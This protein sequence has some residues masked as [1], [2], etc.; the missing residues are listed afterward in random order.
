MRILLYA[1][2]GGVGKTS[3]AAA[4][5]VLASRLG[6]NTLVMS[7]DPAHSLCDAFDLDRSLMDKNRGA[8]IT[9]KDRLSIQELDVHEEISRY[10]GEVHKYISVLLSASGIEDVLAEEL[11]VLPGMEEVAALLYVNQYAKENTYDLIVLDCAPTAESIRFVSLPKTLE[12]YMQKVF[13]VERKLVRYMRPV[14]KRVSDIPLPEDEYFASIESLFQRLQGVDLLLTDSEITS[15]RLV[16]NL[17]KMVLRETQ[18][19]F[20]F[21]S[22]HQL[23]IDAVIIN[24]VFPDG[25]PCNFMESWQKSQKEYMDLAKSYFHPVPLLQIPFYSSEILGHNTLGNLG[26]E[27]YKDRNPADIFY[28]RR[29]CEFSGDNGRHTARIH[30]PFTEKGEVELSKVGEE[31]IVRI[32]NF[33]KN[34][35]LPRAFVPLEPGKA[36]LIDDYLVIDFGGNHERIQP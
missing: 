9:I 3:V 4:T 10:W 34:L 18:R 5:G 31:L 2:K 22:L 11:A 19:A 16:T 28:S 21:F 13:R 15:V 26:Q 36:R 29:T 12:W 33:K 24:R 27:L 30:L 17:E 25:T 6:I 35:I 1:G 14:A 20:M 32:G 8:P 23:S 7:L